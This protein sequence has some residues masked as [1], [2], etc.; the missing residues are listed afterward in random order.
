MPASRPAYL[1]RVPMPMASKR[2]GGTR[3]IGAP[4]P[5]S[6]R[7]G[8]LAPLQVDGDEDVS[9]DSVLEKI[10]AWLA[11][12]RIKVRDY[13]LDFDRKLTSFVS[14]SQFARVM[15]LVGVRLSVAEV[16]VLA[17][18]FAEPG[19][20]MPDFQLNYE[21]FVEAVEKL[22]EPCDSPKGPPLSPTSPR[23]SFGANRTCQA[24]WSHSSLSPVKKIQSK[25]VERRIRLYD[26]FQ[27]F[28]PLRK[29]LCYRGQV[30]TVF[31]LVKLDKE[32]SPVDFKALQDCYTRDGDRFCYVDFCSDID[33]AFTKV[34]L[35]MDPITQPRMP[36]ASSTLPARRSKQT[37]SE[38]SAQRVFDLEEKL[39]SR[40]RL[41]RCHLRCT[42]QD[43]DRTRRGHVTRSQFGRIMRMLDFELTAA[44]VD[45]LCL[46]YCDLGNDMEFNYVEFCASC[47]L[48][49]GKPS[50]H[51]LTPASQVLCQDGTRDRSKQTSASPRKDRL[52]PLSTSPRKECYP[53]YFD[54]FGQRLA[55][56]LRSPRAMTDW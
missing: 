4:I 53:K 12:S 23:Y 49:F 11:P 32:L 29:G 3:D 1:V 20:S 47:E 45:T 21:R 42:F 41:R 52:E 6:P 40:V 10:I 15:Q 13:F 36:D 46:V 34:G 25:V 43:M 56:I 7:R 24:D 18:R 14:K 22:I 16:D 30:K 35:E 9:A 51:S 31:T 33:S 27:D 28:D 38:E 5:I 19:Q 2:G 17:Q 26:H 39:R 44:D 37:L 55:P 48:D 8:E 50:F 54:C